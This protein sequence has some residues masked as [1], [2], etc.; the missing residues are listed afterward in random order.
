[1]P[2]VKSVPEPVYYTL[3][4]AGVTRRQREDRVL[5]VAIKAVFDRSDRD[6]MVL[7]ALSGNFAIRESGWKK[8]VSGC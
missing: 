3:L 7:S 6:L 1:M 2:R 8:I 5:S 4:K